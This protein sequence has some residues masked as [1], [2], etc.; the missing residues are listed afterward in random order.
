MGG[1]STS[2]PQSPYSSYDAEDTRKASWSTPRHEHASVERSP[3]TMSPSLLR[4]SSRSEYSSLQP[5]NNRYS[6]YSSEYPGGGESKDRSI[7]NAERFRLLPPILGPEKKSSRPPSAYSD[8]DQRIPPQHHRPR[9]S[10]MVEASSSNR[11]QEEVLESSHQHSIMFLLDRP[12]R[13]RPSD[14]KRNPL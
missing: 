10:P 11:D 1:A 8:N 4:N 12:I 9:S 5:I 13:P 14:D 2:Q 6:T 3:R 7:E